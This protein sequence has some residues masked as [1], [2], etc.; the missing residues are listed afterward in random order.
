MII[1]LGVILGVI[2]GIPYLAI[3]FILAA[4]AFDN[5]PSWIEKYHLTG[6]VFIVLMLIGPVILLGAF[7]WDGLTKNSKEEYLI[8]LS[9]KR[10]LT[11]ED[12]K[13]STKELIREIMSDSKIE[14]TK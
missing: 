6:L 4:F 5:P 7:I 8:M 11:K 14:N 9:S 13:K 3:G 10:P 12:Y 2:L 1:I